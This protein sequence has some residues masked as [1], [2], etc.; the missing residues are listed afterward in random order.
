MELFLPSIN[1]AFGGLNSVVYERG[2]LIVDGR[3]RGFFGA[4]RISGIKR[5][6]VDIDE[7]T[8]IETATLLHSV[9]ALQLKGE[10]SP[11]FISKPTFCAFFG[12]ENN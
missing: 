1:I 11:I 3:A 7:Y 8:D 2:A 4:F 12:Y 5:L 6:A 9:L 10:K